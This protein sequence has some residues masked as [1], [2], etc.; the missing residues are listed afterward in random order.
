MV[1]LIAQK[2]KELNEKI[3]KLISEKKTGNNRKEKN[4]CIVEL[5]TKLK[6]TCNN[7]FSPFLL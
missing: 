7:S 3:N 1:R 4:T 5:V 6:D 2:R